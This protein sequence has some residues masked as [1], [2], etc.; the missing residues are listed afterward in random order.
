MIEIF[1]IPHTAPLPSTEFVLPLPPLTAELQDEISFLFVR[2]ITC[3]YTE[4]SD[5]CFSFGRCVKILH[6]PF[7]FSANF[8]TTTYGD[9]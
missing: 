4:T 9:N 7:P 2:L 8:I 6:F 1:C 3:M 5:Y